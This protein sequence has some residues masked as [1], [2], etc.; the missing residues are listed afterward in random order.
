[1]NPLYYILLYKTHKNGGSRT[2]PSRN[3]HQRR[4]LYSSHEQYIQQRRIPR[5]SL[6]TVENSPWR[7]V[8]TSK[9]D[10]VMITLTGFDYNSFE[11]ILIVLF[12]P[13]YDNNDKYSPWIDE[14]GYIVKKKTKRVRPQLMTSADC[15]GLV[16]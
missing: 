4:Q 8:Y 14:S 2:C 3:Q 6:V 15:L 5:R 7:K 1:M 16:S 9:D 10:Q 13:T 11:Y 12:S